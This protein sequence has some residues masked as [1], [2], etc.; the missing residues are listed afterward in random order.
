[1][2][3]GSTVYRRENPALYSCLLTVADSGRLADWHI[4]FW[5]P[6]T[7]SKS[8]I[9]MIPHLFYLNIDGSDKQA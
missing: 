3:R 7:L 4:G 8:P 1:M 9:S 5:K 6:G 2:V